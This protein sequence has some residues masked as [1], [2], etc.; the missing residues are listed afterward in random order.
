MRRWTPLNR[1]KGPS[2]G[3]Q[4]WNK[5]YF[6]TFW[7]I[8]QKQFSNFSANYTYSFY[9]MSTITHADLD[10]IEKFKGPHEPL[11]VP[12]HRPKIHILTCYANFL[13]NCSA[14]FSL[15]THIT[16]IWWALFALCR[17]TP[18]NHSKGPSRAPQNN[19]NA[20]KA[21]KGLYFTNH[22]S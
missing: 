18:L 21:L 12:S 15:I 11:K 4:N 22:A 19:K 16:Y 20:I 5:Y 17:W 1:S 2:R 14:T 9:I 10:P 6:C 3:P 13:K 8:S 7:W